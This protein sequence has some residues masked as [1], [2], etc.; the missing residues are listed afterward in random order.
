[1]KRRNFIWY[2]L[3]FTSGC[4]V[5]SDFGTQTSNQ[6]LKNVPKQLKFAVTDVKGMENLERDYGAFRAALE[7]VLDIKIDFFPVENFIAAAPALQLGKVNLALAGP[8]EYIILNARAKAVP[9]V[10]IR[11][12]R[13]INIIW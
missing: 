12:L 2:S 13:N 7:D 3:L 11:H 5:A 8:S 1:M 9:C 6:S 10:S 4:T